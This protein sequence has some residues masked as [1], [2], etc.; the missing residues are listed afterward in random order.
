MTPSGIEPATFQYVAQQVQITV[1]KTF[2]WCNYFL[3]LAFSK[4]WRQ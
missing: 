1:M 3:V 2:K 4:I